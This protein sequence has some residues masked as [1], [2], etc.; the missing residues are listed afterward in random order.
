MSFSSMS[1]VLTPQ[2][3]YLGLIQQS[4]LY[5]TSRWERKSRKRMS[6]LPPTEDIPTNIEDLPGSLCGNC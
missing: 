4:V 2:P 5:K 1:S 3:E 6:G